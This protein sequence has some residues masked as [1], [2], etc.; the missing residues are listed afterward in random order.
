MTNEELCI[1]IQAGDGER[2]SQLWEQ[3][4]RFIRQQA[5][6]WAKAW[7]KRPDIDADDFTQAGYIAMCKAVRYWR[8]DRG[9]AFLTVLGY[10]L[11]TEFSEVAGC[12]TETRLNEPL[13]NALRLDAPVNGDTDEITLGETVASDDT[14]IQDA[15]ESVFQDQLAKT[16]NEAV[17]KLPERQRIAIEGF[18]L[19]GRTHRAIAKKIGCSRTYVA[20]LIK[21]GF[22][23][24]RSGSSGPTLYELLYADRDLYRGTGYAA[25]ESTGCSVQEWHTIKNDEIIRKYK[26]NNARVDKINYC[27]KDL[28][29]DRE[30]AERL[31]PV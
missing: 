17:Y 21:A 13:N 28:G 14:S 18:Y 31:F 30:E 12:K 23:A 2:I 4:Y 16:V 20:E 27:V 29:M 9:A 5:N 25:W 22:N 19:Q 26:L 24:L 15:E 6:K 8:E 11:K 7:E 3:C 1:A 10:Y